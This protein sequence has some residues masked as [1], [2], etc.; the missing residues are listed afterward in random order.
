MLHSSHVLP[1]SCSTLGLLYPWPALS[2]S[3]SA[4]VLLTL[5][6][7]YPCQTLPLFC[8]S[9]S[10]PALPLFCFTFSTLSLIYPV[11]SLFFLYV[12]FPFSILSLAAPS[13]A[14]PFSLFTF[15]FIYP[16][17]AQPLPCSTF[18]FCHRCPLLFLFCFVSCSTLSTLVFFYRCP[19]LFLSSTSLESIFTFV[20][21][22]SSAAHSQLL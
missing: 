9:R 22:Y 18:V 2:L 20:L 14:Q 12:P 5:F 19:S 16:C 17:P 8:S 6:L 7:L 1:Y 15:F 4:L 11:P 21:L 13:S 3:S 10:W